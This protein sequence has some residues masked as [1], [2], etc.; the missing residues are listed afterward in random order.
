MSTMPL[1]TPRLVVAGADAAITLYQ[2]VFGA[3]LLERF[4]DDNGH[5][6]HAALSI[7]GAIISLTEEHRPWQNDAPPSLGGSPVILTLM[8]DDPDAVGQKLVAAGG[9]T[10][11]EVA[12]QFYGHREGRFRD[13]YGHLWILSKIIEKLSPEQVDA[14]MRGE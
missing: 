14:R 12:D 11:F 7:R 5:V 8:V 10:I 13:P 3:E 4:A 1:L 2:D 9:T 6:V